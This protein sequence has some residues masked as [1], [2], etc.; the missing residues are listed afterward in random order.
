MT[1]VKIRELER[2]SIDGSR[3]RHLNPFASLWAVVSNGEAVARFHHDYHSEW[4]A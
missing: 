2:W 1:G 3:S 4:Q